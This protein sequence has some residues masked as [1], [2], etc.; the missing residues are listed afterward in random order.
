VHKISAISCHS[1]DQVS[2][3]LR[4]LLRIN[5]SLFIDNIE[6]NVLAAPV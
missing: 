4:V 5:K 2:M 3:Q 1:N 6:L